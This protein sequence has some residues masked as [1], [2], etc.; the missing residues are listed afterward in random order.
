MTLTRTFL[1]SPRLIYRAPEL[2]D[3]PL[4]LTWLNDPHTRRYLVRAHPLDE[5]QERTF[6]ESC[7]KPGGS[8][9]VLLFVD[10]ASSE[11]IGSV[12]LHRI[13]AIDR[14]AELGL[15]IGPADRRGQGIGAEVIAT[16]LDYGFDTLNLNRIG[17]SVYD[18]NAP[19]IAC[20]EKIGFQREGVLRQH[21]FIEGRYVDVFLYGL[22]ADEWRQRRPM[23]RP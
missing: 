17:L 4:F 19:G 15:F 5:T 18:F 16:M 21:R 14:T 10:K 2:S 13:A 12:G 22:L 3:I 6:I 20:Y 23:T 7:N 1:E 9:V 11:A 8:D